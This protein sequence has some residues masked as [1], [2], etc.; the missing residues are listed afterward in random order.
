MIEGEKGGIKLFMQRTPLVGD[1][2]VCISFNI[3]CSG[4]TLNRLKSNGTSSCSS[5]KDDKSGS[6]CFSDGSEEACLC[7]SQYLVIQNALCGDPLATAKSKVGS[8]DCGAN[9]GQFFVC[10]RVKGTGSAVRKSLGI[11]LKNLNPSKFYSVYD[12]CIRSLGKKSSRDHF[13]YVAQALTKSIKDDLCCGVVGN[14]KTNE[15]K[16]GAEN[17]ANIMLSVLH[18][19]LNL[20]SPVGSSSKPTDHV[21]C[22]H[23]NMT[24]LKCSGWHTY[25][26]R[27]YINAKVKGVPSIIYEKGLLLSID[28]KKWDSI[29]SKLKKNLKDYIKTKYSKVGKELANVVGYIVMSNSYVSCADV[30]SIIKNGLQVDSV[31]KAI[32][33]VL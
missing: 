27:D 23:D 10:W 24:E 31:E 25:V 1:V 16:K 33:N 19:K 30:K 2:A 4:C 32:A 21:E 20:S 26:I 7:Y 11:A 9:N 12:Q 6:C 14:I 5:M 29:A 18:K 13:N 17:L 8:V 15:D 22:S 28:S 3:K